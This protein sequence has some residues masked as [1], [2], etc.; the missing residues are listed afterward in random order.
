MNAFDIRGVQVKISDS[1]NATCESYAVFY[2]CGSPAYCIGI[3]SHINTKREKEYLMA[4]VNVHNQSLS[5]LSLEEVHLFKE[6]FKHHS[7]NKSYEI[8][9]D[10][11]LF[12][13][14]FVNRQPFDDESLLLSLGNLS[15]PINDAIKCNTHCGEVVPTVCMNNTLISV[16]S[17]SIFNI[18]GIPT[19]QL[20]LD[21]SEISYCDKL[22]QFNIY[23]EV[24]FNFTIDSVDYAFL[25]T[26][27]EFKRSG[28]NDS[29]AIIEPY[30]KLILT[31]TINDRTSFEQMDP[32]SVIRYILNREDLGGAKFKIEDG[33]QDNISE[34]L[35]AKAVKHINLG[36]ETLLIDDIRVNFPIDLPENFI[37]MVTQ[38]C[39][40]TPY[41]LAWTT[42]MASNHQEAADLAFFKIENAV[43]IF[44]FMLRNNSIYHEYGI[45]S[46]L[47]EWDLYINES[48]QIA[49]SECIYIE[50]TFMRG[51]VSD[52]R[53]VSANNN[54]RLL[55]PN[56]LSYFDDNPWCFAGLNLANNKKSKVSSII[57]AINWINRAWHEDNPFD[58]IIFANISL[59][60][61]LSGENGNTIIEDKLISLKC[62]QKKSCDYIGHIT[63]MIKN[64]TH[65]GKV[66]DLEDEK[67]LDSII[68]VIANEVKNSLSRPSL[69]SKLNSLIGRLKIPIHEND[70][71]LIEKCR[72]IRNDMVHGRKS[73]KINALEFNKICSSI[74]R[75]IAYKYKWLYEKEDNQ[76]EPC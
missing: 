20:L 62:S 67:A 22:T 28:T 29:C 69:K 16:K 5:S 27:V 61:C 57:Q 49:I 9:F 59:E 12:D 44:K 74:S 32:F 43:N 33:L 52:S 63:E 58:K 45:N 37:K 75:I 65:I 50:N 10:I 70:L 31:S 15:I 72:R 35:V 26:T 42:T 40:D 54:S 68:Q 36:D 24:T 53:I 18:D 7:A 71:E 64:D 6:C 56:E 76:N 38:E 48:A 55:T 19:L 47:S 1:Q 21:N 66:F 8:P 73:D 25:G 3:F 34:Y 4:K 30:I 2:H 17:Y 46:T 14:E 51:R 41:C 23:D 60:F 11:D 39:G 13:K